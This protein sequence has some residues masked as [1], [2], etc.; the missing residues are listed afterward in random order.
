[1]LRNGSPLSLPI[2]LHGLEEGAPQ[3]VIKIDDGQGW[4]VVRFIKIGPAINKHIR[5]QIMWLILPFW[6]DQSEGWRCLV[7][8]EG[9]W[10][11]MIQYS[12]IPNIRRCEENMGIML[13]VMVSRDPH[14]LHVN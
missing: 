3:E 13:E 11:P 7:L 5:C 12:G 8:R 10:D 6:W 9:G 2:R 14:G 1:M 4:G